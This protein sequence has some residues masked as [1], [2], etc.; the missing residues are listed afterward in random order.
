MNFDQ[1]LDLANKFADHA[2]VRPEVFF[3]NYDY[4]QQTKSEKE[5]TKLGPGSGLYENMDKYKSVK[6][7]INSDR[8]M[9]RKQRKKKLAFLCF[10]KEKELD[11]S[12]IPIDTIHDGYEEGELILK[13]NTINGIPFTN[14]IDPFPTYDSSLAAPVGYMFDNDVMHNSY[15]GILS[16]QGSEIEKSLKLAELYYNLIIKR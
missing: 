9:K 13:D 3:K 15:Y 2:Q 11:L 8:K 6:D 7:F 12:D 5:N 4:G 1:L 14:R 16:L 10:A